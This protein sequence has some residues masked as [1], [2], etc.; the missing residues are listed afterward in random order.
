MKEV[1]PRERERELVNKKAAKSVEVAEQS[2]NG[3]KQH[4]IRGGVRY[5]GGGGNA[6]SATYRECIK[7][8]MPPIRSPVR[9]AMALVM[10][11]V[12]ICHR[13]RRPHRSCCCCW[14]SLISV[15]G[16]VMVT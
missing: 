15:S 13:R 10:H 16:V 9:A 2:V 12:S 7:V 14:I 8:I 6:S 4:E 11:L 1:K 5:C 3:A